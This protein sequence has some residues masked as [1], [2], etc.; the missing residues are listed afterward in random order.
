MINTNNLQKAKKLITSS[1]TKL[2]IVRAQS[3]EF[4]RKI[5][6]YGKFHIL[7]SLETSEQTDRLRR[8]GSGLN[9]VLAKIAA[10]NKI[11]I[12]IDIH[13][14]SKLNPKQKAIQLSRIK[15]NIKICRKAKCQIK[16]VNYKDS[17]SAKALLQSLGASSQQVKE[18]I[19]Q[20]YPTPNL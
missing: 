8:S 9:H 10:K 19:R 11:A 16:V 2:I 18:A 15:Q 17:L 12:G 20:N 14:L 5:L 13:S 1:T 4:N 6:E 7:L 3:I